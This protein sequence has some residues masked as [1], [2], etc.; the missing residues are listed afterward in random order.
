MV[1]IHL[2]VN[3]LNQFLYESHSSIEISELIKE[4]ITGK[5]YNQRKSII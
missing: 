5:L 4:L 3:D 2:K 1:V